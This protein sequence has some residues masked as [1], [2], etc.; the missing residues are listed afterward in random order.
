MD[1]GFYSMVQV[2]LP[3]AKDESHKRRLFGQAVWRN[4]LELVKLFVEHGA[5]VHS[6]Q[7]QLDAVFE[8]GDMEFISYFLNAGVDLVTGDPFAKALRTPIK[9]LLRVYLAYRDKLPD[10]TRQL[11]IALRHHAKEGNIGSVCLLLWAGGNPHVPMPEIGQEA[12]PDSDMTALEAA[13]FHNRTAVVEKIG[14]KHKDANLNRLLA[15]ACSNSD[16]PT[17]EKLLDLGADP[18][19]DPEWSPLNR[20][21]WQLDWKINPP[22][23]ERH[24]WEI[25]R[26]VDAVIHFADRCGGLEEGEIENR[27]NLRR[28]LYKWDPKSIDQLLH[29]FLDHGVCPP[30]SL[31]KFISTPKMK[32]VLGDRHAKLTLDIQTKMANPSSGSSDPAKTD[33][34]R[35]PVK[36]K[37]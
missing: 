31:L 19:G 35:T 11:N 4:D 9:P 17:I 13:V 2:L 24:D 20:L 23:G 33:S 22:F 27:T 29:K 3:H 26:A 37:V 28:A 36:S 14:F 18:K 16:W 12:N 34:R 1:T 5:D 7:H 30:V 15:R 21:L 6:I 8:S 25:R 10:L 32:T